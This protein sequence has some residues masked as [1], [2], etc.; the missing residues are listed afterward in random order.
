MDEAKWFAITLAIVEHETS[1]AEQRQLRAK[2]LK[3]LVKAVSEQERLRGACR[4]TDLEAATRE[5]GWLYS[6]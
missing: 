2:A 3:G 1:G 6:A 4:D 5:R